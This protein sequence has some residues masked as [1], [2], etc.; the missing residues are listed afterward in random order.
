MVGLT[1]GPRQFNFMIE[2]VTYTPGAEVTEFPAWNFEQTL[3]GSNYFAIA[4]QKLDLNAF[5]SNPG[6]ALNLLNVAVQE[7]HAWKASTTDPAN[8]VPS[9]YIIDL[10]SS[11]KIPI[12]RWK[13]IADAA[14]GVH[15]NMPG[16]LNNSYSGDPSLAENRQYN[17]S[18]VIYGMWRLFAENRNIL[19]G[20]PAVSLSQIAQSGFFGSGE[21]LV[22]PHAYYYK[23]VVVP[24]GSITTLIPATNCSVHAEVV[25]IPEFAELGQMARL[26]QR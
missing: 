23:L 25:D 14:D 3:Q 7:S 10:I 6:K 26:G 16:F 15:L 11:V 5:N 4:E 12:E 18:Q 22:A 1:I 8:T 19:V 24:H 21:L 13:D 20:A 9:G 2:S 17:S